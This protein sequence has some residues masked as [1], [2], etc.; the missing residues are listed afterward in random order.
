MH[1]LIDSPGY[2]LDGRDLIS[3]PYNYHEGHI[4]KIFVGPLYTYYKTLCR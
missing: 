2:R 4:R 1:M 3:P